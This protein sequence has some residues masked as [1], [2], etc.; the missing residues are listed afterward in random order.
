MEWVNTYATWLPINYSDKK[1]KQ[2]KTNCLYERE[3]IS[4]PPLH[5]MGERDSASETVCISNI[6]CTINDVQQYIH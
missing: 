4:F 2:Q 3:W 5:L 1:K 6:P